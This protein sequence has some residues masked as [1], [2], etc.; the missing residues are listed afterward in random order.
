MKPSTISFFSCLQYENYLSIPQPAIWLQI[1]LTSIAAVTGSAKNFKMLL[2][3]KAAKFLCL[4]PS[5]LY[6]LQALKFTS[7][8]GLQQHVLQP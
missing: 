3:A 8:E 4:R 1:D 2:P 7:T 5:F 6:S